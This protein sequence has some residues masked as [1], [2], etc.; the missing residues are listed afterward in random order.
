MCSG[1]PQLEQL[2]RDFGYSKSAFRILFTPDRILGEQCRD[3]V[4]RAPWIKV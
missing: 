3:A 4:L 2:E 1:K